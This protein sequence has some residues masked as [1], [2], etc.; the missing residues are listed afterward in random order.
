MKESNVLIDWD[1][2]QGV[3]LK[4]SYLIF[5]LHMNLCQ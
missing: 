5:I 2:L 4:S 3:P 1:A